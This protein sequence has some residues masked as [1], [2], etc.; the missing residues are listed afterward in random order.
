MKPAPTVDTTK[1]D[2]GD[3]VPSAR[4]ATTTPEPAAREPWK[5]PAR[6]TLKMARPAHSRSTA[7][8]ILTMDFLV[9]P[10]GCMGPSARG[11]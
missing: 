3:Q 7:S 4:R 8:G 2:G 11:G 9:M 6:I 10:V 1:D 5:A